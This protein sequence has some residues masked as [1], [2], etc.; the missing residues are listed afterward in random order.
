MEASCL[1]A[2]AASAALPLLPSS[3]HWGRRGETPQEMH[4]AGYSL[5]SGPPGSVSEVLMHCGKYQTFFT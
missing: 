3:Q 4:V 2:P 1:P 5:C